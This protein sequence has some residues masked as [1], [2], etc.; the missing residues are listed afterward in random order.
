VCLVVHP[1]NIPQA[2]SKR[3]KTNRRDSKEL[4]EAL[5]AGQVEGIRV[6]KGMYRELRHLTQLRN[7]CA[8]ELRGIKSSIK[9]LLLLEG[10]SFPVAPAG[11]QWSKRVLAELAA[12]PCAPAVRFKLDRKL[13]VLRFMRLQ[14]LKARK[15]IFRFCQSE[16][17]IADSVRYLQSI[18]GI[19]R[20][21]ATYTV[22]RVGDWRQ[23][24]NPDELAAFI[25]LVPVEHSTGDRVER[26]SITRQGD[27]D[28]RSMLIEGAW[29][30]TRKDPELA[31][32]YHRIKSQHPR[33]RAARIAIVAVARKLT[34]RM[35]AVLTQRR[36]YVVRCQTVDQKTG[37]VIA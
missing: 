4:A 20:I 23:L 13:E 29:T 31:A 2:P 37:E 6:P 16:P 7:R 14:E 8:R 10:L 30:A 1:L 25:G 36:E 32:F 9:S 19:G 35:Y 27:R 5:R 12:L 18:S 34:S 15:E 22:A 28:L 26:G 11:S 33:D 17:E 24:R 21:I 3:V